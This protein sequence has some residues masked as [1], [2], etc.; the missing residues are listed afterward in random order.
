MTV[1]LYNYAGKDI[2]A[3][4]TLPTS[5]TDIKVI[6]ADYGFEG[7]QD[8]SKVSIVIESSTKP[9]YNYCYID[10]FS[11]YYFVTA[12]IWLSGNL[13]RLVLRCDVLKTYF[14]VITAQQGVVLYSGMGNSKLY[15][16]RVVY[17][18]P[19]TRSVIYEKYGSGLLQTGASGDPPYL[20]LEVRSCGVYAEWAFED[21][22]AS[23]PTPTMYYVMNLRTYYSFCNFLLSLGEQDQAAYTEAIVSVTFVRWLDVSGFPSQYKPSVV[24][25]YTPELIALHSNPLTIPAWNV[26][27]STSSETY[28]C[29][30]FPAEF[31]TFKRYIVFDDTC[32]DYADRKAQRMIDIPY[33]G[34]ISI[35][36][37]NFGQG[38]FADAFQ[39]GCRISYDFGGN[40]YVVTPGFGPS[41]AT[42]PT[43]LTYLNDMTMTFTNKYQIPFLTKSSYS[44]ENETRIAQILSLVGTA[45]G[46]II[47]GIATEGATVPATV[48]SLGIGVANMALTEQKVQ[49]AKATSLG[50]SGTSNGGSMYNTLKSLGTIDPSTGRLPFAPYHAVLY[51]KTNNTSTSLSLFHTQYGKPDGEYR[52]LTSLNGK[53]FTQMGEFTLSGCPDATESERQEIKNLLMTG[54]IL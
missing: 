33:V 11:R 46:G 27:S 31:Y 3:N 32:V 29:C 47:T 6:S 28:L 16:P 42:S 44:G 13:W 24:R 49:Y 7:D 20:V 8:V 12:K 18:K 51:K 21:L 38:L 9:T 45:V 34:Q 35:D 50:M 2:V 54:I 30:V 52:L 25:F 26:P 43:E 40:E 15:D 23:T 53:G 39:I 19:P 41:S 10:S 36:L 14:G 17:N 1:T 37:D 48:A 4:K 22:P 5:G